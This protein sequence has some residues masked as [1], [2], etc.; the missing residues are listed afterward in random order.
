MPRE[1]IFLKTSE[2]VNDFFENLGL[3]IQGIM[4]E[5]L[6]INLI[7]DENSDYEKKYY[8]IKKRTGCKIIKVYYP[9]ELASDL[10]IKDIDPICIKLTKEIN[11]TF[12]IQHP[13]VD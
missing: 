6:N 12:Q 13:V 7:I 8:E 10:R 2:R 5:N 9:I 4:N 3:L 1:K 11:K